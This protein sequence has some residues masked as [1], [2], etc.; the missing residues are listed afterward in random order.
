MTR[1]EEAKRRLHS[2]IHTAQKLG[3]WNDIQYLVDL[4]D[5]AEPVA[6]LSSQEIID[7]GMNVFGLQLFV[8]SI[9][10][11]KDAGTFEPFSFVYRKI[12]ITLS[13]EN[14]KEKE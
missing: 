3:V 4:A 8:D 2:I 9:A 11:K 13:P 7:A 1:L 12:K 10:R 14:R 6:D 5:A